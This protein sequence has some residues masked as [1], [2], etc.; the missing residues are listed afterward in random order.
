MFFTIKAQKELKYNTQAEI[1]YQWA[2]LLQII[3]AA[4]TV[5]AFTLC[6]CANTKVD[7]LCFTHTVKI[8]TVHRVLYI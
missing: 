8:W 5:S 3:W 7:S 4:D 1:V 2:K 6:S